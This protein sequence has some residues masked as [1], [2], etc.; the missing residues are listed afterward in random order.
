MH[1]AVAAGRA[2][3]TILRAI[4]S[5]KLSA[6]RDEA[7]GSW[8][9]E[10]AELHR[11]YP[12]GPDA[13]LVRSATAPVRSSTELRTGVQERGATTALQSRL[14]AAEARIAEMLE[15]QRLR[16]EVIE[17]LRRQRDRADDERHRAQEQLAA[18]QERIT[19]LLTDQRPAAPVAPQPAPEAPR[20]SW[21]RWR[22]G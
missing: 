6:A 18:A 3:S 2:K 20:R 1:A 22:R 21:W 8:M 14:E 19:A 15:S 17:D 10:P 5:G 9:I 12:A 4:Q 13:V 7:T 11:V 16:D